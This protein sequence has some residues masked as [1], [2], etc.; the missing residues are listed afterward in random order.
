MKWLVRSSCQL[1]RFEVKLQNFPDDKEVLDQLASS[2][3][4]S[5]ADLQGKVEELLHCR[6]LLRGWSHDFLSAQKGPR[7]S[8]CSCWTIQ[9][10]LRE[11]THVRTAVHWKFGGGIAKATHLGAFSRRRDPVES[12]IPTTLARH[13]WNTQLGKRGEGLIPQGPLAWSPKN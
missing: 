2:Q 13:R 12:W 3:Q 11:R 4:L 8:C 9:I 7:A 5:V 1:D 10:P 6:F